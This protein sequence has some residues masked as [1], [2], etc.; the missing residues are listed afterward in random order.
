[1]AHKNPVLLP[2]DFSERSAAALPWVRRLATLLDARIH[3]IYVV[4]H[5]QFYGSLD[6]TTPIA[7]P[8]AEEI[9][10]SVA[11][12]LH[13]YVAENF[14]GQHPAV[15]E[16]ILIGRPADEIVD[17]A[18]ECDAALIVMTTHGYSGVKHVL[19]GSTTEEVLRRAQCPVL[20]I[21]NT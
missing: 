19:L 5:P 4:E 14:A 10:E 11:G 2:I 18:R 15:T 8:T 3:G 12:Q 17:Y 20:S 13:K 6:M 1:M 21:R 7:M 9:A 16:K